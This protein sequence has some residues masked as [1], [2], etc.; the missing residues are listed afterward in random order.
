MNKAI[1]ALMSFDRRAD[2]A[3]RATLAGIA[4]LPADERERRTMRARWVVYFARL[5]A[6]RRVEASTA[7]MTPEVERLIE[8]QWATAQSE[9]AFF[10]SSN[11][12]RSCR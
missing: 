12:S 8:A 5:E 4:A 11:R 2:D 9:Q 7:R 10:I 6:I 3:M 1:R